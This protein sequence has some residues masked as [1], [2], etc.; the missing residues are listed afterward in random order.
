[1]KHVLWN[2]LVTEKLSIHSSE[3]VICLDTHA[4]NGNYNILASHAKS[5]SSYSKGASSGVARVIEKQMTDSVPLCVHNYLEILQRHNAEF[6]SSKEDGGESKMFRFYPGSPL[7]T[8]RRLRLA[9]ELFLFESSHSHF[10][11]LQLLFQDFDDSKANIFCRDGLAG[12]LDLI[13]DKSDS[14]KAC[15]CLIDPPYESEHECR[16]VVEAFQRILNLDPKTTIMIWLPIFEGGRQE[17]AQLQSK[18]SSAK[19]SLLVKAISASIK[20]AKKGMVGSCVLIANPPPKFHDMLRD[21]EL[22]SWL[23]TTLEQDPGCASYTYEV[24]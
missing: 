20:V 19:K 4:G 11:D 7:I 18:L 5:S 6:S 14:G 12:A 16:D 9:D 2:M 10:Q 3:G 22:L 17:I 15:L 13:R 23:A 1:M 24:V 8:Q 21:G